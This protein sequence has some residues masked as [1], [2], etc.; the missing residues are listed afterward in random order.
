[1]AWSLF[2]S[3]KSV[4]GVGPPGQG[5]NIKWGANAAEPL[6][7]CL[8]IVTPP[9]VPSTSKRYEEFSSS[10][11][12]GP[13]SPKRVQPLEDPSVAPQVTPQEVQHYKRR[14]KDIMST[15]VPHQ[16]PAVASGLKRAL[17]RSIT[18]QRE[19]ETFVTTPVASTAPAVR[20]Q[21]SSSSPPVGFPALPLEVAR[22]WKPK[23]S[24]IGMNG[25]VKGMGVLGSPDDA[26][27][28]AMD[29]E[30]LPTHLSPAAR[31]PGAFFEGDDDDEHEDDI[32]TLG[33]TEPQDHQQVDRSDG[34]VD[35]IDRALHQYH[36]SRSL[37]AKS[38]PPPPCSST[39][40]QSQ[41]TSRPNSRGRA[42][43]SRAV[44]PEPPPQ[45]AGVDERLSSINARLSKINAEAGGN[46][47]M[48]TDAKAV[49]SM[50]MNLRAWRNE[51]AKDENDNGAAAAAGSSDNAG[52]IIPGPFA[53]E[54]D[55]VRSRRTSR[56]GQS[57]STATGTRI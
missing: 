51:M 41:S 30:Y 47:V 1:M 24:V 49:K 14:M 55:D 26:R 34:E 37:G 12:K 22:G 9:V 4:G 21:P 57:G 11:E 7:S 6:P 18:Q 53:S 27:P 29:V 5:K 20:T 28:D 46:D 56:T 17:S 10:D 25:P 48:L 32:D 16:P 36:R 54:R 35:A 3:R 31:S 33:R 15:A 38:L 23:R 39:D 45:Q 42:G 52:V 8:E 2:T 19:V 44:T 50:L 13:A 43:R 40:Q